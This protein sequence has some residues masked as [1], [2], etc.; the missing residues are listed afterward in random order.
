MSSYESLNR[1][2]RTPVRVVHQ[3][4]VR[5][6]SLGVSGR[7]RVKA[8]ASATRWIVRS[9]MVATTAFALLDLILLVSGGHH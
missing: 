1:T 2:A 6:P 7:N 5:V 3:G 9:V 4:G 8:G